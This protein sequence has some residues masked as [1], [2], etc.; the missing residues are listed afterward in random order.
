MPRSPKG[1]ITRT[2]PDWN[3]ANLFVA[4]WETEALASSDSPIWFGLNNNASGAASLVVWDFNMTQEFRT[5]NTAYPN[6]LVAAWDYNFTNTN[7]GVF[8][9][10]SLSNPGAAAIGQP[11]CGAAGGGGPTPSQAN[12][13]TIGCDPTS[14][15]YRWLHEWPMLVIPPR[16]SIT[17]FLDYVTTPQQGNGG[18]YGNM[19][20]EVVNNP[21]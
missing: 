17:F 12:F 11:F 1:V 10:A 13:W 14:G 3:Y 16:Y 9:S 15:T 5:G 20:Y 8:S 19:I 21:I 6:N 7:G 18:V 2:W 4:S